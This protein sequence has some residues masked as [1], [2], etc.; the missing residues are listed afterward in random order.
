MPYNPETP[1]EST[2]HTLTRR[3]FLKTAAL[4]IGSLLLSEGLSSCADSENGNSSYKVSDITG[5]ETRRLFSKGFSRPWSNEAAQRWDRV[6]ETIE[7]QS[8]KQ[9]EYRNY[10]Y[11]TIYYMYLPNDYASPSNEQ[12]NGVLDFLKKHEGS[13]F[14]PVRNAYMFIGYFENNI[15]AFTSRK[16][17]DTT[18]AVVNTNLP[19]GYMPVDPFLV[20]FCQAAFYNLDPRD[21][22][23]DIRPQESICNEL[24]LA[25]TAIKEGMSHI[26]YAKWVPKEGIAVGKKYKFNTYDENKYN[27]LKVILTGMFV[28]ESGILVV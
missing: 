20:E 11:D 6:A 3:E 10:K 13:R 9:V 15:G 16:S 14:A 23:S 17:K 7:T 28:L 18:V 19:E 27:E 4:S 25:A 26:E 21:V 5:T 8:L 1:S 2:D 22:R 24:G 12:L